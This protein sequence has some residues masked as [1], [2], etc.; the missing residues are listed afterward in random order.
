MKLWCFLFG[1]SFHATDR[2]AINLFLE[3][4][5]A[6]IT[7][8]KYCECGAEKIETYLSLKVNRVTYS[9]LP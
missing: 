6:R 7:I 8:T 9:T 4:T 1:H 2:T 3:E 5:P